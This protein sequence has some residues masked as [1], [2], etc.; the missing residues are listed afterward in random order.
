[1]L[2]TIKKYDI[3]IYINGTSVQRKEKS[4][5]NIAKILAAV[6]VLSLVIS[7]FTIAPAALSSA[8]WEVV[9]HPTGTPANPLVET[10]ANHGIRLYHE[11]HY[12]S[13]NAGLLYTQPLDLKE[14]IKLNVTVETDAS[15]SSD[16]W[17]GFFLMNKPVYFDYSNRNPDEGAGIVLLV[18]PGDTFQYHV[19][20]ET[21]FGIVCTE[22][23]DMYSDKAYYDEAGVTVDFEIKLT[24]KKELLVYV[25]GEE[26]AYD[27]SEDVLAYFEDNKA[28]IG[29]SM[30]DTNLDP[31]SFVINYLNGE[32]PASEGAEITKDESVETKEVTTDANTIDYDNVNSFT[33]ID[34]TNPD[35]V[36]RVSGANNCK[37]SFD[38]VDGALKVEVTG[39]DP[40]FVISM[41]KNQFFD[42]DKFCMIRMNYKTDSEGLSE[43]FYTTKDVP[44]MEL[45]NL[46]YDL[47]ATE[48]E[49]KDLEYDMQES[50]NWA[51]QIRSFRIDPAVD[52]AEGQVFYYKSIGFEV[53]EDEE[54]EPTNTTEAETDAEPTTDAETVTEP[55]TD[56]ETDAQTGTDTKKPTTPDNPSKPAGLPAWA[57]AIIGVCAAA[58]I[59]VVVVLIVKKNKK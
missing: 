29:F 53:W 18:R 49:Y 45:C 10:T 33:F 1:M 5:K 35:S 59:A 55:A 32:Q 54:T 34:F 48:G 38:E 4:M 7:M 56:A 23:G 2:T 24:D 22:S 46:Q 27:F 17:Y 31:Q 15:G 21:Q 3:I 52:P 11:G 13:T 12:P 44:S 9:H 26:V 58:I 43:F 16:A 14:G 19:L 20:N 40:Y 42:G 47:E 30:S 36:K 39:D 8:D 57:W 50:A 25:D 51:G 37:V 41:K 28:Y 6:M